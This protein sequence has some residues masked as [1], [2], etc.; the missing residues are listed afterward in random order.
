[1]NAGES[2][3][4]LDRELL[5]LG[6]WSNLW[7]HLG[8]SYQ[9]GKSTQHIKQSREFLAFDAFCKQRAKG[10]ILFCLI[11]L[12]IVGVLMGQFFPVTEQ[13]TR[14]EV[15]LSSSIMLIYFAI[16]G[17]CGW[18]TGTRWALRKLKNTT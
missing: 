1:M 10:I 12:P 7:K 5:E 4:S 11:P 3:D 17:T 8:T 18:K 15:A 6:R 16:M 2:P 13:L 9:D 14:G